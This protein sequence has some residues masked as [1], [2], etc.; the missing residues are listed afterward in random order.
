MK[1]FILYIILLISAH[2]VFS[3][4]DTEKKIKQLEKKIVAFSDSQKVFYQKIEVLNLQWIREQIKQYGLPKIE[5]EGMLINHSAM[6]LFYDENHGQAQWVVHMV[7]PAIREGV[8]TRTNDF[9]KDSMVKSG[10]PG[11]EDYYNTGYDRGH[12]AASADFRWSKRAMSESYYYSNMSP[13]KPEFNRGKWSQLEDFVRQY[14]METN[15]PVF[16]VT[17]GILSDSL[18]KIG[19]EKLISV[20]KHYYK[21]IVDLNDKEKKGI[22]FL[23]L[24]GTNTKP[25]IS[26]AVSIDSIEKVTGINFFASLPDTLEERIEKMSNVDAWLNKEQ[27]GSVKPLEAEELPKGAINTVDAE[28]FYDQKATVCGTVVAVKVLKDSKGIVFNLDTKFPNQIFSFTI[29]KSNVVNFS[30]EPATVLMD[31]KICLTGTI[32]KYR[33]KP[34]MELKNEK[35]LEF[36]GEDDKE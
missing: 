14:V 4:S 12:L 23:M 27:A 18:K 20:P 26:Y 36:L 28:K 7:I 19:K 33:D 5:S 3:Q 17:G 6:S 9:R 21:I 22:A 2:L 15:D 25:I 1:S 24:N 16:V 30:Y 34:T 8:L 10:T 35:S 31:K 11:K 32:T 13:Q 29:W